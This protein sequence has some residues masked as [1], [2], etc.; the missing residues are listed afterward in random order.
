MC[1]KTL[2]RTRSS[3]C[4]TA[5]PIAAGRE[6]LTENSMWRLPVT[7]VCVLCPTLTYRCKGVHTPAHASAS[8]A[9]QHALQP[10]GRAVA[11]GTHPVTTATARHAPAAAGGL[12]ALRARVSCRHCPA[13]LAATMWLPSFSGQDSNLLGAGAGAW[14]RGEPEQACEWGCVEP[15]TRAQEGDEHAVTASRCPVCPAH[16]PLTQ[17]QADRR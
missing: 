1:D 12:S 7:A 4:P 2:N 16:F 3:Q 13:G 15:V 11:H 14:G 10:A 9:S 8:A 5:R 17:Q 6:A